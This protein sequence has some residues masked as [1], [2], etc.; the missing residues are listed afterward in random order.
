M[1][2]LGWQTVE[3]PCVLRF[4]T[5]QVREPS[6]E[7]SVRSLK[8]SMWSH[9]CWPK[10]SEMKEFCS[11]HL[12]LLCLF[13]NRLFHFCFCSFQ[14]TARSSNTNAAPALRAAS[15]RATWQDSLQRENEETEGSGISF[16]HVCKKCLT[17]LNHEVKAL[18]NFCQLHYAFTRHQH[19]HDDSAIATALSMG[20]QRQ[21]D[22]KSQ[23]CRGSWINIDQFLP[24]LAS[25]QNQIITKH[26]YHQD[27]LSTCKASF[28]LVDVLVRLICP[29]AA[30]LIATL[31]PLLIALEATALTMY[32][33]QLTRSPAISFKAWDRGSWPP[34]H[35][36]WTPEQDN[37][38][39]MQTC[40]PGIYPNI[41]S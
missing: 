18:S 5:M 15:F 32:I 24:K 34:W 26:W 3:Q 35:S 17:T 31:I 11:Q 36:A 13:G 2:C 39:R 40:N 23:A 1:T 4:C 30:V 38:L 10:A 21:H 9:P 20:R 14:L 7:A 16:R 22:I 6:Q 33:K 8:R 29:M 19:G 41:I 25:V 37:L 27:L 12:Q 28:C